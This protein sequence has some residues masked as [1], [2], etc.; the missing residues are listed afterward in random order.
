MSDL[1]QTALQVITQPNGA[2]TMSSRE[3]ATLCEKEHFHV[4]RDIEVLCEQLEVDI[5]KFGGIYLDSMNREQT[6]YLLDKETCLCLVTG[7]SA[8]LRMA[9]IKRWQELE[10]QVTSLPTIPKAMQSLEAVALEF[11][12]LIEQ[13]ELAKL[14]NGKSTYGASIG[15]VTNITGDYYHWR[16]LQKWCDDH[17]TFPETIS[18]N[19]YNSMIVK[20]YPHQAWLDVYELDLNLLFG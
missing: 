4:K 10:N 11:Q 17:D 2:L 3:I 14:E 1:I 13:R 20:V 16:P 8:K 7:Y 5:S 18:L 19:G 15:Q 6:E 9:I 12:E